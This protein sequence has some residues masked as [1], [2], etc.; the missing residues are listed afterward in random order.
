MEQEQA[1][2]HDKVIVNVGNTERIISAGIGAFLVFNNIGKLSLSKLLTGGFLLYRGVTGH[3]PGYS[4]SGK[5]NMTDPVKNPGRKSMHFGGSWKIC[6]CLWITWKRLKKWMQ[7][8]HIGK[9]KDPP[10]SEALNGMRK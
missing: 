10:V 8:G 9:P 7:Q 1:Y 3:C 4:L 6:P 2:V 5:N